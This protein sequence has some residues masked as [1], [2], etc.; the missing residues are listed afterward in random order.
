MEE[1]PISYIR[2]FDL[3]FDLH[4]VKEKRI[5]EDSSQENSD[6]NLPPLIKNTATNADEERCFIN[7]K[8]FSKPK[9]YLTGEYKALQDQFYHLYIIKTDPF[10]NLAKSND[11][12]LGKGKEFYDTKKH[13]LKM[14]PNKFD[15]VFNN[16]EAGNY[17]CKDILGGPIPNKKIE[18]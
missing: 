13:L 15:R 14:K 5:A 18:P 10:G 11:F 17:F 3:Q 4:N 9:S 1:E 16:L 8:I 2:K 7:C 12:D 6:E